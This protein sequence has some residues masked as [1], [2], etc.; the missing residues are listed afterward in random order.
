MDANIV[1]KANQIIKGCEAAELT[2]DELLAMQGVC[3]R[4]ADVK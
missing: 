3:E 1:E 2:I 4:G